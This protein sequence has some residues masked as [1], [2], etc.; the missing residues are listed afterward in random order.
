MSET[1]LADGLDAYNSVVRRNYI[2]FKK[3]LLAE[4]VFVVYK[5]ERIPYLSAGQLNR[6][7]RLLVCTGRFGSQNYVGSRAE[8][9]F[10]RTLGSSKIAAN[11]VT[12]DPDICISYVVLSLGNTESRTL[13]LSP[14]AVLATEI[15]GL[16]VPESGCVYLDVDPCA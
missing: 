15:E 7:T 9:R 16:A 6:D 12:V 8:R 4:V 2:S 10:E 3:Y 14:A 13:V 5:I 11:D 1:V